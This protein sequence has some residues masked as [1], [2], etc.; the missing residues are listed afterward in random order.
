[1]DSLGS[2]IVLFL[3][4]DF[5]E[6]EENKILFKFLNFL[7]VI[8]LSLMFSCSRIIILP[9]DFSLLVVKVRREK[10]DTNS[11]NSLKDWS[12]NHLVSSDHKSRNNRSHLWLYEAPNHNLIILRSKFFSLPELR[13]FGKGNRIF[14]SQNFQ[15][16]PHQKKMSQNMCIF[17]ECVGVFCLLIEL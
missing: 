7:G 1:M 4:T 8:L 9:G 2:E 6:D 12:L 15:H 17:K 16:P 10:G 11:C 13:K 5:G 3:G 14:F